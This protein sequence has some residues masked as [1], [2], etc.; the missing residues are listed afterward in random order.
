MA[1]TARVSAPPLP[2][3]QRYFEVSLFLLVSTGIFAVISTGKLDIFSTFI[4]VVVLVY[5][6]VPVV[7]R[8]RPRNFRAR[9]HRP[10]AR[11]FPVF[12]D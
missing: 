2:A 6:A 7:A 4:P 3:V 11:L 5:K 1:S 10:G 9:S 8:T 12:P